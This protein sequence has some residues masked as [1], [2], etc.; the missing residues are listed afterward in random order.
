[1]ITSYQS[2]VLSV[3]FAVADFMH[4]SLN[5]EAASRYDSFDRFALRLASRGLGYQ[6]LRL[7]RWVDSAAGLCHLLAAARGFLAP[8][9]AKM[10]PCSACFF[11][12]AASLLSVSNSST[13]CANKRRHPAKRRLH[14]RKP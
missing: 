7:R 2:P 12:V 11:S 5:D 6:R 1:M 10:E 9:G 3:L 8:A 13:T 4:F 14:H